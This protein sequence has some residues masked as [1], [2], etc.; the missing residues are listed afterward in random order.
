[1]KNIPLEEAVYIPEEYVR[2]VAY[3]DTG[4]SSESKPILELLES[5]NKFRQANLTPMFF[6]MV[7]SANLIV[8]TKEKLENKFH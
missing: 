3:M 2:Y 4:D 5:A 8:T 1:M 6:M 7:D